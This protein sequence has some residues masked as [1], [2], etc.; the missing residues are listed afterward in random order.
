MTL[1]TAGGIRVSGSPLFPPAA[2]PQQ[3][4]DSPIERERA[5]TIGIFFCVS[6]P[7][8]YAATAMAFGQDANWDLRNYHW[9][10]GYA[11]VHGRLAFDLAPAQ[12]PSFY[13]PA[14]DA[15]F[16]WTASRV[17]ARLAFFCLAL[18]QGLNAVLVFL[19][20]G[21]VLPVSRPVR[22]VLAA[23][24]V[25]V[26]GV[27]GGGALGQL[28]AVFYDNVTSL[29]PLASLLI[30]LRCRTAFRT[31]RGLTLIAVAVCAGL[32]AGLAAG[33]K[34]PAVIYCVALCAAFLFARVS[35]ARRFAMAFGFGVGVLIGIAVASGP[36]MWQM[37]QMFGNP[38][39]PYFHEL[40]GSSYRLAHDYHD[41][42]FIPA[43]MIERLALPILLAVDPY[44][45]GE[46]FF[47]DWRIASLFV[48]LLLGAAMRPLAKTGGPR[49]TEERAFASR[50]LLAAAIFGYV[51]WL[52]IFCI[53]RYALPLEM[54]APLG[55]VLVL[56]SLPLGGRPKIAVS[57]ALLAALQ[58]STHAADWR[59]VPWG[60]RVVDVRLPSLA[61]DGDT[62]IL[63][64]GADPTSFVIPAF[65]SAI[66]FVRIDGNFH[67]AERPSPSYQRTVNARIAAYR[68]ALLMLTSQ[69][70][71]GEATKAAKYI[72]LTM[73]RDRCGLLPNNLDEPLLLCAVSRDILPEAQ[74]R[75]AI[76]G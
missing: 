3:P 73:H 19:I 51:A 49:P 32:P 47:R 66:P 8:L 21:S 33:F 44:R 2:D 36:W 65:P 13:N 7:I 72:G 40:F 25:A 5:R 53:Y 46:V 18:I 67:S 26:V 14:L 58:L 23:A 29:G 60:D 63:M 38:V 39:F 30:V 57:V 35:L 48:L 61:G 20:A 56:W 55:A 12:T 16:F 31:A 1:F 43:S 68:G 4:G 41:T 50:Y 6:A 9:Y 75:V 42:S 27:C 69:R 64:A 54:L 71:E 24:I 10:N 52:S 28:G 15:A 59:R 74:P 76:G 45:V 11:A 17:P 70:E 34:L 22:R 62:M 37:Q